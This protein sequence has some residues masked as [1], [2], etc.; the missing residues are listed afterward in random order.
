MGDLLLGFKNVFGM[1]SYFIPSIVSMIVQRFLLL[2]GLVAL[3]L[4]A[5]LNLARAMLE[6]LPVPIYLKYGLL[7]LSTIGLGILDINSVLENYGGLSRFGGRYWIA[8]S[9]LESSIILELKF[10]GGDV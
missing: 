3:W 9:A 5:L 8:C 7:I 6:K 10:R 2:L 4:F 1:P